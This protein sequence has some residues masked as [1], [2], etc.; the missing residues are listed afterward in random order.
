MLKTAKQLDKSE[1]LLL[2]EAVKAGSVDKKTLTPRTLFCL[3]YKD[4]FLGLQ[5]AGNQVSDKKVHIV[6]L[7]DAVKARKELFPQT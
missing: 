4:F 6:C 5:V 7:G 1:K 2:L 3:E